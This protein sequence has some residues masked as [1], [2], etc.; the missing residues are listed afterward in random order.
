TLPEL[1]AA[2]AEASRKRPGDYVPVDLVATRLLSEEGGAKEALTWI[3]RLRF[4]QPFGPRGHLL[5]GEALAQLGRHRQ[6]LMEYR[7]AAE[8]GTPTIEQVVARYPNAAAIL[9][10]TP[11]A[12][13][14]A[15]RAALGLSKLGRRDDAIAVAKRALESAPDDPGLL[16]VL[17]ALHVAAG[18]LDQALAIAL[19]RR[20]V[21][22]EAEGAWLD[23]ANTLSRLKR[24]DE[25]RRSFEEGLR[26][27][28]GAPSLVFG[29]AQLE[30]KEKNPDQALAVL[31]RLRLAVP[32]HTR[33]T[34]HGLRAQ[35][36]RDQRSL[37]KARDELRLA[38]RLA[39]DRE[40]LRIQL[41]DVLL[42]LGRADEAAAEV[43][44]LGD[45]PAARAARDRVARQTARDA[46]AAEG[47]A[48]ER[49]ERAA[50]GN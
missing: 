32:A 24:T 27:L 43:A 46:D 34:Y 22:P 3:N 7:K 6:A 18:D 23:E 13:D 14:P 26:L 4:L 17:H 35:A 31:G 38:V 41:S 42:A 33:A 9:M 8:L 10:G 11:V 49:L 28:P 47:I 30:L 2:A 50:R 37:I 12:A 29:L 21:S 39:P 1:K 16:A 36:F 20:E 25:S 5:A 15:R 44:R 19:K 40:G 45:G 48:R